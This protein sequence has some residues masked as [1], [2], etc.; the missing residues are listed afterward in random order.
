M[1]ASTSQFSWYSTAD[2]VAAKYPDAV[3]GKTVLITGANTGIGKETA[4]VLASQGAR[5][6]ML[7]RDEKRA[8]EAIA[9]IKKQHPEADVR[10]MQVDLMSQ[11]SI[12]SFADSFLKTK[13][14][15]NILINNAGIMATP[16]RRTEEGYESQLG[17]N[18]LGH[19][20]LTNL[21]LQRI[22]ESQPARIVNL[23]SEA[24]RF[25]WVNFDDLNSEKSYSKWGA[26]G[27][28]KQ[29]NILFSNE[30]HRR[31]QQEGANVTSVALHPGAIKTE[32]A[33]D[34]AYTKHIIGVLSPLLFK[35]IPQGAAT[36]VYAAVSSDLE[37]RGGM[38]LSDSKI[39][40]PWLVKDAPAA[41]QRLWEWSE[42]ATGLKQ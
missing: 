16:L 21:L 25:G 12:R 33:R 19:F 23:S 1:G 27:Q 4:R 29:A 10:F 17:V 26:Y 38:Y 30:L 41:Q 22:K 15:I 40:V 36:T 24:H 18:H 28:S 3:K 8:T 11:K 32:L 14:P 39:A 9:D 42:K 37:G 31:L 5:V 7:C 6:Y 35:S 34:L 2:E 13:E 20:L